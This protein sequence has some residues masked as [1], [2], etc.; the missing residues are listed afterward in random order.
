MLSQ[1]LFAIEIA[2]GIEGVYYRHLRFPFPIAIPI[3][4]KTV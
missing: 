1:D 2:I 3:P 4:M